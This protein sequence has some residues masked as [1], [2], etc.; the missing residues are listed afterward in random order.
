M[1]LIQE[2]WKDESGLI[3]SAE[4]VTLGTVGVLGAVVGLNAAGSA[5][6]GELKEMAGAIRSLDQSYAFVGHR[7]CGAWTAGSCYIQPNVQQS[8]AEINADGQIDVKTIQQ[9]I[10][11]E[12]NS[13][14]SPASQQQV[15]PVP[16]PTPTPNQIQTQDPQKAAGDAKPAPEGETVPPKK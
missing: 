7:G 14:S 4:T 10:E 5:V 12:R 9:R 2:L 3:L 8:L 13:L 15:V 11:D 6:N 16:T 1:R